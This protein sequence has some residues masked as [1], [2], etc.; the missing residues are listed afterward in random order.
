MSSLN[1]ADW[2]TWF[3]FWL[4]ISIGAD[5]VLSRWDLAAARQGRNY[6]HTPSARLSARLLGMVFWP[7]GLL[8]SPFALAIVAL[9]VYAFGED[10]VFGRMSESH[11][12]RGSHPRDF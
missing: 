11:E 12:S 5:R 7:I 4:Y 6:K 1:P 8:L 9:S 10:A 3:W 2:P